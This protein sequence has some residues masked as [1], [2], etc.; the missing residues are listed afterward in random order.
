MVYP[1]ELSVYVMGLL[2]SALSLLLIELDGVLQEYLE[3][4]SVSEYEDR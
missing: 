4:D 2:K 3:A 1:I